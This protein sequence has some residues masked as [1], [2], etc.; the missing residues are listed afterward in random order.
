MTIF[1]FEAKKA[2]KNLD[3]ILKY[4]KKIFEKEPY[5][6]LQIFVNVKISKTESSDNDDEDDDDTRVLRS[7]NH[8]KICAF[9]QTEMSEATGVNTDM[10]TNL[11]IKYLEHFVY[12]WSGKSDFINNLLILYYKKKLVASKFERSNAEFAELNKKLLGFLCDT[13]NY[14]INHALSQ[15]NEEGEDRY[16][17]IQRNQ[18]LV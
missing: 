6:R 1:S 3:L 14:D 12:C 5:F 17:R 4:A 10:G 11:L 8:E 16:Y 18:R 7:L 13:N 15:F 2:N 9:L